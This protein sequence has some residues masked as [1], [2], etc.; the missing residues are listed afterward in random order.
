MQMRFVNIKQSVLDD[1]V[2]KRSLIDRQRARKPIAIEVETRS[3]T[4]SETSR[5]R[6]TRISTRFSLKIY[7][8]EP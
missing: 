5:V 1:R 2:H 8:A 3:F 4:P 6:R 7:R